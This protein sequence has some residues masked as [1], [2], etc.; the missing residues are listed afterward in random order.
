MQYRVS[1][2][3]RLLATSDAQVLQIALD[4]GFGCASHFYKVFRAEC[5][6]TPR[7]YRART[8]QQ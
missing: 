5:G 3:Q 8:R 6:Q 2:A 7:A 1:S 4:T